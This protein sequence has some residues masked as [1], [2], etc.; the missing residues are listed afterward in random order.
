MGEL[1]WELLAM[2]VCWP[3]SEVLLEFLSL[4]ATYSHVQSTFML[5]AVQIRR[6]T[7]GPTS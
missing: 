7:T 6:Q 4:A 1:Y 5:V 3:L 2:S